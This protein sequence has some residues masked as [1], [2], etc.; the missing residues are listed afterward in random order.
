MNSHGKEPI[1]LVLA[2]TKELAQQIHSVAIN[3]GKGEQRIQSICLY[4]GS[5]KGPQMKTL[6]M[7]V[8]LVVATPGR[9]IDLLELEATNLDRCSYVVI[10]EADR[11]LD[12]GFEPQIR[13][14]LGQVRPDRQMLMW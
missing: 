14:I 11:M 4:G 2:P 1:A 8:D 9:L 12:M 6:N 10:D 13:K 3:F 5:S 7:G